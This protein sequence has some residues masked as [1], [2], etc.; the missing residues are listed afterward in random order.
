MTRANV[1]CAIYA[2]KSSEEGLEQSF[3][4]LEA[5]REA[6]HAFVLSQ[7]HEGWTALDGHYDDGG[8][9]GGNMERPALKR[10]LADIQAGKIQTV[11]VYKVDRLTRSLTDFSKIIE[12]FDSQKVSFVSVTQN[13]N[14]T[15]SMGRLTLNVLLSFAQF[16]REITGERIRDKIAASK[17][18]GMWMGGLVPMGY[19][20]VNRQ[21]VINPAEAQTVLEIF[22]G[23]LRLKSV[24]RLKQLLDR[25]EVRSKIRTSRAG[26]TGGGATYSRGAL[27]HLL[28]NRI[29]LG[30]ITHRA[31]SYP[32]QHQPIVPR[33]LWNEVAALLKKQNQSHRSEKSQSSPSLLS[34][35]LFD[36]H[37]SRFT[38]THAAKNGKRY[39]YYTS[40]AVIRQTGTR[41]LIARF[42]A[43]ELERLVKSQAFGL[44]QS[45]S[46]LMG[47]LEE[48]PLR[49]V[50]TASANDLAKKWPKWDPSKQR[51]VLGK[52]LNRVVLGQTTVTI[53]IDKAKLFA[54]LL[55]ENPEA[56]TSL[57]GHKFEDI[58]I[59][60]EFQFFRRGRG[61][62]VIAATN[63]SCLEGTP[64]L[65]LAKAVARARDWYGRIVAGEINSIDQLAQSSGFT[66][67]YVRTLMMFARLSPRVT[68]DILMGKHRPS[69]TVA[70]ILRGVPLSWREQ[71]VRFLQLA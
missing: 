40:Q 26:R 30:E 2:R 15:S 36:S 31:E 18:K 23:Y 34:G 59:T 3:N 11:I 20:C 47:N 58:K 13:F 22:R 68:E 9:S 35:K 63:G 42:P 70:E 6:C 52:T 38:P 16:E 51:E 45:P 8:F 21:L 1:R 69:L 39:R 28:N 44:L 12:I 66:R 5:Q 14:T 67:R 57:H 32:G 41:P 48:G 17:K 53:E 56:L 54:V 64:T 37:G 61:L 10:L 50:A 60:S 62:R 55:A 33:R 4:S 43:E 19:D 49:D 25:R 46:K 29:Y 24:N 27:Y 71:E 7:K 65:S